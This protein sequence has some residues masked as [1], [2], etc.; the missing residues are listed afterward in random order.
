MKND[1]FIVKMEE[2]LRARD[3]NIK[4]IELIKNDISELLK[5]YKIS[6]DLRKAPRQKSKIKSYRVRYKIFDENKGYWVQYETI[7]E[8]YKAADAREMIKQEFPGCRVT[9]AWLIG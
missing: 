9:S 3:I 2:I 6:P 7:K 5:Q 4:V 8:G 1:D